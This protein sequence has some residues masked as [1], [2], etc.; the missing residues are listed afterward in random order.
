MTQQ[1]ERST[2]LLL[3]LTL[4]SLCSLT[5][6]GACGGASGRAGDAVVDPESVET[7]KALQTDKWIVELLQ[8]PT[9]AKIIGEG[10]ITY[11]S[12]AGTFLVVFAKIR[13]TSG[14]LQVVPR[15]LF[16]VRDG[17][18]NEYNASKSAIQVAYVQSEGKRQGLD[19]LLDSP[20]PNAEERNG[21]LIFDLPADAGNL[22]LVMEGTED[23][24]TLGF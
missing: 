14:S 13:N 15:R 12:E 8:V 6:L 5:L 24:L 2:R 17:A 7:G 18:G 4:L 3:I 9:Q 16:L 11:Q 10:N 19:I 1:K 21:V 23:T 20:I 22:V